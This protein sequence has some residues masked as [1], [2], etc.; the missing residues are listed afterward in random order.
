MVTDL[1]KYGIVQNKT[2]T[3]EFPEINAN[4][5][6]DYIRGYFDGDGSFSVYCKQSG[7]QVPRVSFVCKNNKFLDVLSGI[8]REY[9]IDSRIYTDRDYYVLFVRKRDSLSRFFDFIY[10]DTDLYL[11]RKYEKYMSYYGS[12]KLPA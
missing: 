10:H 8:M 2:S 1:A 4:Y 3:L 9:G 5:I 12:E 7:T 6:W 11:D